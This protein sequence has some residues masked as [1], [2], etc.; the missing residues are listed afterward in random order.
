MDPYL[1]SLQDHLK[2][3]FQQLSILGAFSVLG[4]Q[5]ARAADDEFNVRNLRTLA[6]RFPTVEEGA[7]LQEWPSFKQHMLTGALKVNYKS[8]LSHHVAI[9][10]EI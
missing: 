3:R 2:G 7:L 6:G 9:C 1:D 8:L 5:A 4:P 10:K